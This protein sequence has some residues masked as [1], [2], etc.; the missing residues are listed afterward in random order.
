MKKLPAEFSDS[1]YVISAEPAVGPL[2]AAIAAVP[3][4]ADISLQ[5]QRVQPAERGEGER[6]N[7]FQVIVAHVKLAQPG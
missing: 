2:Y 1:R 3:G 7:P 5:Q 4:V 6:G